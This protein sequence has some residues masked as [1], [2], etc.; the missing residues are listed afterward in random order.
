MDRQYETV[1]V[2]MEMSSSD[3]DKVYY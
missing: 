1:V 2:R 3:N